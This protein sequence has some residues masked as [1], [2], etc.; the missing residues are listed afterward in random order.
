M[1]FQSAARFFHEKAIPYNVNLNE[2]QNM[3][4]IQ[5]FRGVVFCVFVLFLSPVGVM[6]QLTPG[7]PAAGSDLLKSHWNA[8][9]KKEQTGMLVLGSWALINIGSGLVLR[10]RYD[11]DRR[12]FHTMNAGW[13]AVNLGLAGFGYFRS[14]RFRNKE[15]NGLEFSGHYLKTRQTL[16]FN[17]GLD[18]AYMGTGWALMER[19]RHDMK[20]ALQWRGF[21]QSLLLQGA[22]LFVFDLA[23]YQWLGS[24]RL[25]FAPVFAGNNSMALS[26]VWRW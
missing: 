2:M 18:L 13:N 26:A 7:G 21:G 11:D 6:A 8:F 16:L 22:F 9:L 14:L 25:Q 12:H 3:Q 23:L 19:S 5:F 15:V 1:A 20:D 4:G 17:A 10:G 24:E